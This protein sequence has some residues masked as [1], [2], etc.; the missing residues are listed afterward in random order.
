MTWKAYSLKNAY[1]DGR[2][3]TFNGNGCEDFWREEKSLLTYEDY[4]I[5]YT[6]V[7]LSYFGIYNESDMKDAEIFASNYV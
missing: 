3:P 1:E 6:L 4:W 2:Y 5:F 7:G